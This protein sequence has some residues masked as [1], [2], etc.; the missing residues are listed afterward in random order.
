MPTALRTMLVAAAALSGALSSAPTRAQA[1]D[2]LPRDCDAEAVA[3][4]SRVRRL[5]NLSEP[6][7]AGVEALKLRRRAACLEW[8]ACA[9]ED[10]TLEQLTAWA[11]RELQSLARASDAGAR[12]TW[13][14]GLTQRGR[15]AAAAGSPSVA[16]TYVPELTPQILDSIRL[17]KGEMEGAQAVR[18][19]LVRVGR[20]VG[21]P[22][23]Q[24]PPICAT[25]IER[26]LRTLVRSNSSGAV[27]GYARSLGHSLRVLCEPYARWAEP[28]EALELQILRFD[29]SLTRIEGWLQQVIRCV[30]PGPYDGTCR[31]TFG[32]QIPEAL[33]D[34]R[35]GLR[36]VSRVRSVLARS[37]RFPC[38][39]GVWDRIKA[40]EWTLRTAEADIPS[41]G[42]EAQRLCDRMG[43]F[44]ERSLERRERLREFSEQAI[45]QTAQLIESY[46][47]GLT[48]QRSIWGDRLPE[49]LR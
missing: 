19:L 26:E 23:D 12:Q 22:P 15:E 2:R 30:D 9:L 14:R 10:A 7:R 40:T 41:L 32:Q 38:Y 43:V 39:D 3:F 5:E 47:R 1:C 17:M 24:A 28:D 44:G 20:G 46:Q 42:D 36:E 13:A 6:V 49:D 35:R 4:E 11:D 21:G 18:P 25:P 45:A 29:A 48:Q 8:N 34:A 31:N 37:D 16:S 33:S 27:R